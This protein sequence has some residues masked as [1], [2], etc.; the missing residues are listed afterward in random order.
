MRSSYTKYRLKWGGFMG[1]NF[2]KSLSIGKL[3]RLNFS[4]KGVSTSVGVKGARVSI[5]KNGVRET[6]T[7]PGTGISWSERQSF[8]KRKKAE[9]L[10]KEN[11]Q[12]KKRNAH[13]KTIVW[14]VLVSGAFLLYRSGAFDAPIEKMKTVIM[15]KGT[16]LSAK[17]DKP[18]VLP[19]VDPNTKN[20][21]SDTGELASTIST[22]ETVSV[23]KVD[24]QAQQDSEE[25]A[26]KINPT[27]ETNSTAG[28]SNDKT[29][30]GVSVVGGM[31]IQLKEGT[32]TLSK[33]TLYVA[34]K[35]GKKFHKPDCRHVTS[36][37]KKNL[38]EY[39]SRE[40]AVADKE[41]CSVCQP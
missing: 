29:E 24:T 36:I 22:E 19:I 5:G 33:D 12:T 18:S 26:T 15:E 7:L 4:K 25:T 16:V 10:T 27:K 6:L 23:T 34:S 11:D 13:I 8:K 39:S 28:E 21:A 38:V 2:R 32:V 1:L 17:D 31:V 3:V 30:T 40:A 37:A 20:E 14:I 35:S 9:A 41:P